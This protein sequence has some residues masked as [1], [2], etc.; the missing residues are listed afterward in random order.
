MKAFLLESNDQ[1]AVSVEELA[2]IGVEYYTID[3]NDYQREIDEFRARRKYAEFDVIRLTPDTECLEDKL[4]VF[5]TEHKHTDEEV[6]FVLDGHGI[7]DV[8]NANDEWV[9][10]LVEKNDLLVL[11]REIYH[12]FTLTDTK[13]IQAMRL[14]QNQPKWQAI[15]RVQEL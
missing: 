8:R 2:A 6:R 12:R 7:F 11:P 5:F 3:A 1:K 10:I 15:N 4:K 14:F 9:R 13:F